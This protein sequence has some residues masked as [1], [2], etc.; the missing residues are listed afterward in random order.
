MKIFRYLTWVLLP[1]GV[2]LAAMATD[3]PASQ[4]A[5]FSD[6]AEHDMQWNK[7]PLVQ[8]VRRAT[9]RYKDINVALDEGWVPATPCVSGPNSGAMGVHFVK[10][11]RIGDGML[12]ADKPEA[13]IYEPMSNGAMRLV[14][15]EFIELAEVWDASSG[16]KQPILEG[17]LLNLVSGPNRYALP[18]FYEIHVWAWERNPSG[19]FADWNNQVSCERQPLD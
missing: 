15:V 13:L 2:S 8:K 10:P 11:E 14:G 4:S 17:H 16:G 18:A 9:A 5:A 19:S 1:L 12:R 6:H 3:Q 7:S